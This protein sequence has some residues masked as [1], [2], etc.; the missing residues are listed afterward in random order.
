M[1]PRAWVIAIA[2]ALQESTLLNLDYGDRDS[3][4]LFQQRPSQGW[5]TPEQIMDPEYA[6]TRF[7]EAFADKVM[8]STPG[9]ESQPLTE[10]AQ[11]VQRSGFPTAYAKWELMAVNAV[12]TVYGVP[13][14]EGS[15]LRIC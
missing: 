9:W 13:P 6:A 5:G 15:P 7:Y 8:R 1:P 2:T 4:G 3:L 11:V 12:L 10:L 14:I